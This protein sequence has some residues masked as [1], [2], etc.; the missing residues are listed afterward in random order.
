MAAK[1]DQALTSMPDLA[2]SAEVAELVAIW[3]MLPSSKRRLLLEQFR[4]AAR[5]ELGATVAPERLL[6][7]VS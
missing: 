1:L 4:Q 2:P 5:A 3:Q 6:H 7:G